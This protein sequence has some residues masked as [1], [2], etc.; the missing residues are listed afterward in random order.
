MYFVPSLYV[1][2]GRK[3]GQKGRISPLRPRQA[4]SLLCNGLIR[5]VLSKR[6]GL[7]RCRNFFSA[8]I[9]QGSGAWPT[10]RDNNSWIC[11]F[12]HPCCLVL[13]PPCLLFPP[14]PDPPPSSLNILLFPSVFPHSLLFVFFS[15]CVPV[16]HRDLC[17][18][19]WWPWRLC[20]GHLS[21]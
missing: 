1:L 7:M 18:G 8:A 4:M 16:S 12:L 6:I 9:R 17:S 20:V 19:L 11:L 14:T 5:F 10:F 13:S 15:F 3:K 2:C 21:M